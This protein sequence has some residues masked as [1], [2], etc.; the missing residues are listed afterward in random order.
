ME[1]V[2]GVRKVT[3]K[4]ASVAVVNSIKKLKGGAFRQDSKAPTFSSHLRRH[5]PRVNEQ[6]GM[7]QRSRPIH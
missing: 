7:V 6:L 5:I 2:V 4:E 3:D 1:K